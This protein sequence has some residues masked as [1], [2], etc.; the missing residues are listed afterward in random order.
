M[1]V[2]SGQTG[3]CR[4]EENFWLSPPRPNVRFYAFRGMRCRYGGQLRSIGAGFPTRNSSTRYRARNEH[5]TSQRDGEPDVIPAAYPRLL[6][7]YRRISV[8]R[9]GFWCRGVD[10]GFRLR[11]SWLGFRRGCRYRCALLQILLVCLAQVPY[12]NGN[13]GPAEF[14]QHDEARV[15]TF[16]A[17]QF[18]VKLVAVLPRPSPGVGLGESR[19]PKPDN[20]EQDGTNPHPRPERRSPFHFL[21]P[22]LVRKRFAGQSIYAGWPGQ[23]PRTLIRRPSKPGESIAS[24]GMAVALPSRDSRDGA[25]VQLPPQQAHGSTAAPTGTGRANSPAKPYRS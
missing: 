14:S 15:A 1:S 3:F 24:V 18:G 6:L 16:S 7:E 25:A 5:A 2:S 12:P 22:Q 13:L 11:R 9:R 19:E 20:G 10:L 23:A 8:V 17:D 21:P 4:F